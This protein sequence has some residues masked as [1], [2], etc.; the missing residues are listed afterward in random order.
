MKIENVTTKKYY[1]ADDEY[2]D[3]FY[4]SQYPVCVDRQEIKRLAA[5]WCVPVKKLLSEVHEA[6]AEEIAEYGI[7][8]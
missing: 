3:A 5:A 7:S 2:M 8:E 4:G 1:V 6:S